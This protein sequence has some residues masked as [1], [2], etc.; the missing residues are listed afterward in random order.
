MIPYYLT[1]PL[2]TQKILNPVYTQ[3]I[4]ECPVACDLFENLVKWDA[5]NPSTIVQS[6]NAYTGEIVLNSNDI[7]KDSS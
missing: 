6:F 3:L 2:A 5:A 4:P 7:T 1:S